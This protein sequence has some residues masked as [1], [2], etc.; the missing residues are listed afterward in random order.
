MSQTSVPL[1]YRLATAADCDLLGQL[2]H[3][4]IRDEGHRNPM[5]PPELAARMRDW[6]A[7]DYVAVLFELKR[8][9]VAHA[10]FAV[11]P[12]EI[13]LRQMF[14]C[15]DH[16]RA[17]IGR[18]AIAILRRDVW[19]RHKRVV[20]E[21]LSHNLAATAFWRAVGFCDYALTLE[22]LPESD[23]QPLSDDAAS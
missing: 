5:T 23:G 6:L 13:Y 10:L 18:A 17:G 15:R 8:Q 11:R 2:N 9:V 12:E 22:C 20:V 21:V 1:S 16:R 14:V 7:G 19:P 3:L 4:L